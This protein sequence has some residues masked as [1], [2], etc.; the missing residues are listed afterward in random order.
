[1]SNVQHA[2]A[3][4]QAA[5]YRTC[6]IQSESPSPLFADEPVMNHTRCHIWRLPPLITGVHQGQPLMINPQARAPSQGDYNQLLV[7]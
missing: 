7:C 5:T 4:F 1:M 3:S 6:E 2:Y